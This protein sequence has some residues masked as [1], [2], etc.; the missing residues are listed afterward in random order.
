MHHDLQTV[1][2]YFDEVMLLNMRL[3]AT[4]PVSD[5]FTP[6]NLRKTYGGK[7][8]LLDRVGHKMTLPEHNESA[9]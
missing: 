3:V 8:A 4:G 5:V 6:E 2:E 7:L 1:P 9:S